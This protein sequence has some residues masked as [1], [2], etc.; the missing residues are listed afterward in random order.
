M[1]KRKTKRPFGAIKIQYKGCL[2]HSLLELKFIILIENKCSWIRE[3]VA[4]H[5]DPETLKVTNY[6]N[7]NTRKYVPDFLV[8][9]WSDNTGYLI[10]IKPQ[11]FLD[12][13]KMFLRNTIT[14]EYLANKNVDWKFKVITEKDI[15]LNKQQKMLFQKVVEEN[16]N[17]S[18]KLGIIKKDRKFNNT[19][20]QYF[21]SVPYLNT[22]DISNEDYIRFVR[23]GILPSANGEQNII[24]DPDMLY[25]SKSE[26]EKH[27]FYLK[28]KFHISCSKELFNEKEIKLLENYGAWLEA[29]YLHKINPISKG[30]VD[31][32]EQIEKETISDNE[33]VKVWFKYIKRLEIEKKF[34]D[35][36]NITYSIDN[37]DFYKREDYYKLHR[38]KKRKL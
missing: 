2:Y 14:K 32:I 28:S 26:K 17:F 18:G 29:L 22:K 27:L 16:K 12:S 33:Y 36:L 5:Y 30:Q 3:P 10:E 6:L 1:T 38:D 13:E 24:F 9:K 37:N 20:Q 11:K 15:I 31:F 34:G 19:P 25:E 23:Y 35:K 21:R 7:E 8:R 4:I